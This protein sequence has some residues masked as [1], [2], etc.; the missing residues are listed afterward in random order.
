MFE[1]NN[2]SIAQEWNTNASRYAERTNYNIY[3]DEYFISRL[4]NGKFDKFEEYKLF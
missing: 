1:D 3:N 4:N 2:M